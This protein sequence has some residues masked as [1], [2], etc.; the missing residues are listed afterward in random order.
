MYLAR[1]MNMRSEAQHSSRTSSEWNEHEK[2]SWG[3]SAWG[4]KQ[5]YEIFL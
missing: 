2:Y 5:S 1:G 3:D 4:H